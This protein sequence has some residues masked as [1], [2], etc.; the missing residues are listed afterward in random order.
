MLVN[1]CC[2]NNCILFLFSYSFNRLRNS[3]WKM[4]YT[5]K[6]K[7]QADLCRYKLIG[8][9]GIF[10]YF[11]DTAMDIWKVFFFSYGNIK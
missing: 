2:F 10:W 7:D 5:L 6:N 4:F 1:L 9:I 11:G 3:F 8:Q